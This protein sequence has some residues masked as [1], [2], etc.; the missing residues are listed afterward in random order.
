MSD[1]LASWLVNHLSSE[2]VEPAE[3]GGKG[4]SHRRTVSRVGRGGGLLEGAGRRDSQAGREHE[5]LQGTL[6]GSRACQAGGTAD[7]QP[8]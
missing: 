3:F 4:S 6:N 8:P 7:F 1:S 5:P 2:G